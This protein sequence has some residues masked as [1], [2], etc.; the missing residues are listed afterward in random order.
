MGRGFLVSRC[1]PIMR[2]EFSK[3]LLGV[4]VAVATS[5]PATSTSQELVEVFN[6][7][8]PGSDIIFGQV[9]D[10]A[11]RTDGT[12]LVLDALAAEV[13]VLDERGALVQV[14]GG[15]GAGPGEF[16]NPALIATSL[17]GDGFAVW[18]ANLFRMSL[19]GENGFETSWQLPVGM[20]V[21]SAL[22]GFS[23]DRLIIH[24]TSISLLGFDTD[25]GG[26]SLVSFDRQGGG[27]L[28]RRFPQLAFVVARGA[29]PRIFNPTLVAT[30]LPD[31]NVLAGRSDE[32][33]LSILD[34]DGQR[35]GLIE[36]SITRREVPSELKAWTER[37]LRN[38]GDDEPE[39]LTGVAQFPEAIRLRFLENL[40][41]ADYL[42]VITRVLSGTED[43]LLVGRGSGLADDAA[44]PIGNG[45]APPSMDV[46][47][48]RSGKYCGVLEL[49]DGFQ[50]LAASGNRLAGLQDHPL[51]IPIVRVLEL[52]T[53]T[54]YS[55]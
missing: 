14:H 31:G 45:A 5:V 43:M 1:S 7:G 4:V 18:D 48:L 46:F 16:V 25:E 34:G 52:N 49:P 22:V 35:V 41:F 44:P 26:M 12:L 21:P 24:L 23:G 50:V 2:K 40:S 11:F 47:D 27:A 13:S 15:K 3:A 29:I 38:P 6:V 32:Y 28:V 39:W 10:L 53:G 54:T 9:P 42:P 20:G 8:S 33:N 19:F 37:S 17:T 36:R 55:C 30:V 51:D